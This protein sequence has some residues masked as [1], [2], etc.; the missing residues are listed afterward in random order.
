MKMLFL[1]FCAITLATTTGC[2][3]PGGRGGG[4]WHGRRG[5][6]DVATPV[7]VVNAPADTNAPVATPVVPV[8][9]DTALPVSTVGI[10]AP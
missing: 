8:P 2:F 4:G 7:V 10:I 3:F 9:A 5:D 6:V 1:L